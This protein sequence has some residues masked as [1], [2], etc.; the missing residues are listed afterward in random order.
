MDNPY[1]AKFQGWQIL[2]TVDPQDRW[3]W[4]ATRKGKVADPEPGTPTFDT[5]YQAL[6]NAK[7][8]LGKGKT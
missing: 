2:L 8:Q 4:T 5:K 1:T 3:S 7:A 6:E